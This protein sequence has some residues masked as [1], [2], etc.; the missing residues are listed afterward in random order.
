MQQRRHAGNSRPTLPTCALHKPGAAG[1]D[2]DRLIAA[3]PSRIG[4]LPR[5]PN[6][7]RG[8]T[9]MVFLDR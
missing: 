4:K 9:S 3:R 7:L 5:L 8:D 6:D 1:A 2:V